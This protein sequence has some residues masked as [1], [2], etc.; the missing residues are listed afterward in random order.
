MSSREQKERMETYAI[1]GMVDVDGCIV[2]ASGKTPHPRS[3]SPVGDVGTEIVVEGI[4]SQYYFQ[5]QFLSLFKAINDSITQTI[6]G[7]T[8]NEIAGL[9]TKWNYKWEVNDKEWFNREREEVFMPDSDTVK[10]VLLIIDPQNDFHDDPEIDGK[11]RGYTGTLAVPGATADSMRIAEMIRKNMMDID[12][13]HVTM[14][15]HHVSSSLSLPIADTHGRSYCCTWLLDAVEKAHCPCLFLGERGAVRGEH[16]WCS[17]GRPERS[18][19]QEDGERQGRL[20]PNPSFHH[21]HSRGHQ[22]WFVYS[23]VSWDG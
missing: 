20:G 12:E 14:D 11:T 13:I 7:E 9:T 2:T 1:G 23:E 10:I 19:H 22:E 4:K 3:P 6:Y 21:H 5:H 18:V 17:E 16:A 15:T 8:D